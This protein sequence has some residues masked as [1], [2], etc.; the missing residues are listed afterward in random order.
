MG[1]NKRSVQLAKLIKRVGRPRQ[2][3]RIPVIVT[4]KSSEIDQLVFDDGRVEDGGED[5]VYGGVVGG[6]GG[7]FGW[8]GDVSHHRVEVPLLMIIIHKG[9]KGE[10]EVSCFVLFCS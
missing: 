7:G 8:G 3:H 6:G 4:I 9:E 1:R 10:G 2:L 5:G